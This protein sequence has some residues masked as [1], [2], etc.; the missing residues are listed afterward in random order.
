[1]NRTH[2]LCIVILLL[3]CGC[4]ETPGERYLV[5]EREEMEKGTRYDSLF[6]GLYFGMKYK[7]FREYCYRKNIIDHEFKVGG[8]NSSWVEC[9]LPTEMNYPAAI[10][11][12]PEFH[13]GVIS[14]MNALVYYDNAKFKDG[15]FESDSLLIDVLA[16]MKRW[17][18]SELIRI[19]GPDEF[20]DDIYVGVHGNR[21]VTVYPTLSTEVKVWIVDL[22]NEGRKKKRQP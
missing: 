1:M 5:L 12:Y 6:K 2:A 19:E 18:G 13:G 21:R 7:T 8:R 14:E 11:F 22:Y 15:V 16:L 9:K 3:L 10:N 4:S 17:Y 20:K